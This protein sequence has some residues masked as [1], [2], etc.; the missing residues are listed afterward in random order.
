MHALTSHTPNK[1]LE[2]AKNALSLAIPEESGHT[3]RDA[4][5]TAGAAGRTSCATTGTPSVAATSPTIT[6]MDSAACTIAASASSSE[7]RRA[8]ATVEKQNVQRRRSCLRAHL[9]QR[10]GLSG[11][12]ARGGESRRESHL[13]M[14][15]QGRKTCDA[16]KL[17]P[18]V[19]TACE[20]YV[21]S[22]GST[23]LSFS[24]HVYV[25]SGLFARL[26]LIPR[27]MVILQ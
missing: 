18:F 11:E 6:F 19:K 16:D 22:A 5:C 21:A 26:R 23:F 7:S 8:G 1:Q 27:L 4:S 10:D 15:S 14:T 3:R 17:E 20:A 2:A 24:S 13:P 25:I 9:P 12:G